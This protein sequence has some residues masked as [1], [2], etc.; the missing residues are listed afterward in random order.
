M[1]IRGQCNSC[2]NDGAI[3]CTIRTTHK[4]KVENSSGL[5]V[6]NWEVA[7]GSLKSGQGT[8]TIVVETIGI[9][10]VKVGV[11]CTVTDTYTSAYD[12]EDCMHRRTHNK[13]GDTILV[14][15]V[16]LKPAKD[17]VPYTGRIQ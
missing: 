8:D 10:S 14:P 16:A 4:A 11:R 2:D 9:Y 12:E 15:H 1:N 13:I 17:L 6:Y 5:T 7:G 3:N